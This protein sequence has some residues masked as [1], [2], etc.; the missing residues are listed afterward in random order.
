MPF[1]T[2]DPAVS[3]RASPAAGSVKGDAGDV[4]TPVGSPD[5]VTVTVPENPPIGTSEI[6][7]CE[8]VFGEMKRVVV[9]KSI[10]KDGGS[11]GPD[12]LPPP[13]PHPVSR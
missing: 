12:E 1:A 8:L 13:P 9:F 11:G 4:V 6:L 10:E 7:T 3:V 5:R 2:F